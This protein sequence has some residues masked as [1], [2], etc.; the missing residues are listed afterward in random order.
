MKKYNMRVNFIR[1]LCD[2]ENDISMLRDMGLGVAM[3]NAC[4]NALNATEYRTLSNDE[5]G[6]AHGIETFC[7]L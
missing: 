2:G 1:D 4:Q 5:D 3:A 7:N 6:V